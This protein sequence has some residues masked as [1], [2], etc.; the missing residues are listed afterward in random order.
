MDLPESRTKGVSEKYVQNFT[1][2]L[3][4]PSMGNQQVLEEPTQYPIYEETDQPSITEEVK[5]AVE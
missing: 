1:E 4:H 5:K 2:L 3:N